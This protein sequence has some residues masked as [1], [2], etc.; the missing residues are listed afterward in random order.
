[1]YRLGVFLARVQRQGIYFR[2]IHPGYIVINGKSF[3]LIDLLEEL[4]RGYRD[5]ADL[6]LRELNTTDFRVRYLFTINGG[7]LQAP[8]GW[9]RERAAIR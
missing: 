2:S 1:M 9:R 4:L 6:L 5:A 8:F 3:G 7:N